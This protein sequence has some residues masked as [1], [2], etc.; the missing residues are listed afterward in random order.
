ME[1]DYPTDPASDSLRR[2]AV[3]PRPS[4]TEAPS[5]PPG[6][7]RALIHRAEARCVRGLTQT[8]LADAAGRNPHH[9]TAPLSAATEAAVSDEAPSLPKRAEKLI[10]LGEARIRRRSAESPRHRSAR[11]P[12]T[13]A[14][15]TSRSLSPQEP[16]TEAAD[17][18]RPRRGIPSV[19]APVASDRPAFAAEPRCRRSDAG[20]PASRRPP[21]RLARRTPPPSAEA[22]RF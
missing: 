13:E 10:R 9:A 15:D 20:N 19:C 8:Q 18:P 22:T 12:S 4:G 21:E 14:L 16:A 11:A 17:L 6:R 2:S 7:S 3:S 5:G 1:I